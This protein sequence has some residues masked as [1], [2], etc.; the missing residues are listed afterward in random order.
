MKSLGLKFALRKLTQSKWS[1]ALN[2]YRREAREFTESI[3]EER[4]RMIAR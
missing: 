2:A 1:N 4:K 3:R